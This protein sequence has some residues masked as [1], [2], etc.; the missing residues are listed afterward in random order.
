MKVNQ[1]PEK[2]LRVQMVNII[3]VNGGFYG[4]MRF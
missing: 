2:G 4:V 3:I 1:F